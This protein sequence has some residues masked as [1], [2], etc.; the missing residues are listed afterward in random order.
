MSQKIKSKRNKIVPNETQW[1]T[2]RAS[3]ALFDGKTYSMVGNSEEYS[4]PSGFQ[5]ASKSSTDQIYNLIPDLNDYNISKLMR[6]V[7]LRFDCDGSIPASALKS[8]KRLRSEIK[9]LSKGIPGG[10]RR[11]FNGSPAEVGD[12]IDGTFKHAIENS[13]LI[14]SASMV[15]KIHPVFEVEV[16]GCCD[17]MFDERPVE[18]KSVSDIND[19]TIMKTLEGNWFQFAAYNWL[20]GQS[21]LI[22]IVSRENL[23]IFV[24]EPTQD[25]IAISVE[26]WS[27]W[28]LEKSP[29]HS[30][31]ITAKNSNNSPLVK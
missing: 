31:H 4:L 20:Y 19:Y 14:T 23:G 24:V 18:V 5:L 29:D 12:V 3:K 6:T 21:P 15:S 27:Q 8:E 10:F 30:Q 11:S 22:V 1:S 13:G 28:S 25:M 7:Q 26:E 16:K 2:S 17:G 9:K